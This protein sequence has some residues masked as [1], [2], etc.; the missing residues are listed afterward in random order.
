MNDYEKYIECLDSIG[1]KYTIATHDQC[2]KYAVQYHS[3]G[4]GCLNIPVKYVVEHFTQLGYDGFE[5]EA[6]FGEGGEFIGFAAWE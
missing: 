5:S 6:C 3:K 1:A 2:K 4:K